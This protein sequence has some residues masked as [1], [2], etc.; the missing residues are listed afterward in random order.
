MKK[1]YALTSLKV[2]SLLFSMLFL[3]SPLSFLL[4][5]SCTQETYDT[6]EGEFSQVR[7]DL[8]DVHVRGDKRVDYVLTDDGDSLC[9]QPPFTVGWIEKPDTI[10]RALLYFN[11]KDGFI[12]GVSMG[13][14]LVPTIK[15][16]SRFKGGMKTDAVYLTSL[17]RAHNGRYLNL[18]LRVMTGAVDG[19]TLG[20]QAFGCASDTLVAHN[21]GRSTL[22][23]RLYH[24]QG[25]QPEYYSREVYLSIPL[26]G[27]EADTLLFRVN[28]YDGIV[29]KRLALKP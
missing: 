18:R 24:D 6:G 17:W 5:L 22:H 8:V 29:E 2:F 7:A 19:E 28:T 20:K 10:Y 23:L 13:Q 15:P 27:T 11:L 1:V 16:V 14:V 3:L 26:Q 12:D 25:G 9:T 4:F 21:D